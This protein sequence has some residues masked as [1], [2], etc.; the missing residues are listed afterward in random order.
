MLCTKCEQW[1]HGRC[2]KL[3]KVT[4]SAA[5]F[6]VCNKCEKVT[7]GVGEVQQKVMCD[8][9]ET[10]K[11]FC[12]LGNRLNANGGCEAVV[13]A[14][15]RVG[16]KKF[17]KCGKILFGT[18]FSLQMKGKIY[19][20]FVR[21][22]MLYRSKMWCLRENK[23]VILRRAKRSMV[24]V[25]CG[26]KLVNKRNTEELMDMLGLKEAARANGVRWYGH[27]LR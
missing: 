7:N 23:V 20:S 22:A 4:P 12:Y 25:M 24:R 2:S 9:V 18:R 15:T 21:S 14:R 3:K 17:S 10:V 11:G 26:V 5:R 16:W 13:T 27:V 1:I 6:F 19:K 8:E